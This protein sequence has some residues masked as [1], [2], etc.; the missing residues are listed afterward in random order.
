MEL[1]H[2]RPNGGTTAPSA[3][4]TEAARHVPVLPH[5]VPATLI[6]PD[7]STAALR[8]CTALATRA[9][10]DL[11][12]RG[13]QDA[14]AQLAEVLEEMSRW[15]PAALVDPDPT[16]TVLAAAALQDLAAR[17]PSPAPSALEARIEAV[18]PLL[19]AVM[20]RGHV[21]ATA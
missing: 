6:A 21:A 1:E 17:L 9:R 5:E 8:R 15:E 4:T 20:D 16:M 18:L 10:A 2:E 11:L 3:G 14:S 19:R 7:L 12:T 13:R